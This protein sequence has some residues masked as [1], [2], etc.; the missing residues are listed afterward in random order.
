MRVVTEQD[1]RRPEFKDAQVDDYE[2]RADGALVRKDRWEM[3]IR[4]IV[5][6]LSISARD[7]F[8]IDD[9]V[10]HV[11]CLADGTSEWIARGGGDCPVAD[12]ATVE[13]RHRG[14]GAASR[15]GW[16]HDGGRDDI[17]AYRLC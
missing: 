10:A 17:V 4:K 15:Y 9:V 7:E 11:E 5:S 12:E 6:F 14:G 8:E 13:A 16:S 2:F 3:G 1:F